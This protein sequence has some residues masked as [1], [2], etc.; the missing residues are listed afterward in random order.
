MAAPGVSVTKQSAAAVQAAQANSGILA[1]IAPCSS[2]TAALPYN[3]PTP[4]GNSGPGSAFQIA[5]LEGPLLE[6]GTYFMGTANKPILAIRPTTSTP[7][8]YYNPLIC[9]GAS[10][11]AVVAVPSNGP[12]AHITVT[13]HGFPLTLPGSATAAIVTITGATGDTAINGTF[14]AT[15]ID[16]NTLALVGVTGSGTYTASSG[17]ITFTGLFVSIAGT[18]IPTMGSVANIADE[19]AD[20]L[21][22]VIS[23]GTLGTGPITLQ[24]SMDGGNTYSPTVTI[25]TALTFTPVMPVT[26]ASTGVPI[27]LGTSGETYVTGDFFRVHPVPAMMNTSDLIAALASL[28]TTEFDWDLVFCEGYTSS[29]LFGEQDSWSTAQAGS[30]VF[31]LFISNTLHRNIPAG[32]TDAAFQT[33]VTAVL[34][35][36]S[37]INV[38]PNADY[39]DYTSAITGIVKP[40]PVAI[41]AAARL[42]SFGIGVDAAAVI[43]G[44]LPASI[45]I[46]GTN[47]QPKW[48]NEGSQPGLDSVSIG[49]GTLRTFTDRAGVYITN[50]Y[51]HSGLGSAFVYAQNARVAN[52]CCAASFSALTDLLSS[53]F[54]RNPK[55]G[56]IL[57][58][59]ALRIESHV[60]PEVDQVTAGAVSGVQF[61]LSRSDINLGNAPATL[62]GFVYVQSLLYAKFFV[63]QQAF[64]Q[65]AL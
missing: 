28:Q 60:Q 30:G 54:D 48:H 59:E 29:G 39:C 7:G 14:Q 8:Y 44:P 40:V 16:A 62:T 11:Q 51:I 47:G 17:T 37:S 64:T 12:P 23:G 2:S 61:V 31:P 25:T 41:V 9:G 10:G 4:Y 6:R 35:G 34:S 18:A 15:V 63:V 36:S 24:A 27:T 21:V 53:G 43:N 32:Q 42:E 38:C 3:M 19:Y 26:G 1:I 50:E 52:A 45:N 49:L 57:E 56:F 13:A 65:T 22:K 33:A 58:S 20:V 5:T 46:T 55:T